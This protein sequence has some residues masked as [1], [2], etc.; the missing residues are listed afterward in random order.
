MGFQPGTRL[1]PYEIVAPLGAGGMGEVY[2]ARDT[3]LSR[4]VA[5][6]VMS[7]GLAARPEL[8]ERFEREALAISSLNHPHICTLFD[9]G[10][11]DGVA[12]FVMEFLEG[13]TLAARL[14]RG[15]L[16]LDQ[17]LRYAIEIAGALDAAHRQGVVHRDLKPGNIL[18]TKAGAKLLDFGL[19]KLQGPVSPLAGSDVSTLATEQS[20]L[21]REGTILGTLHYMAP[22]QLHGQ[23]ADA[24]SDLFAFGVM[25]YEMAT[26]RKAFDGAT[27]ASVIAA[28]LEREPPELSTVQPLTPPALERIV[29]RCLLKDP[30]ERWQTARDLLAELKW[31]HTE[32]ADRR[33]GTTPLS[34]QRSK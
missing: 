2:R 31:V 30:E 20:P 27:A 25:V 24:R 15:A 18:L 6:K 21:T 29:R 14:A 17:V 12:Y 7:G 33:S 26:G 3:R 16:P 8:R 1:G 34:R 5:V 10:E 13:E 9:V 22:E 32:A 23:E 11:H 19:A 28:I 4:T